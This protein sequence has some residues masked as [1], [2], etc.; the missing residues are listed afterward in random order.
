MLVLIAQA[1]VAGIAIGIT[2]L[3]ASFLIWLYGWWR[4]RKMRRES[5]DRVKRAIVT[6]D[7]RWP[8]YS[9]YRYPSTLAHPLGHQTAPV[10]GTDAEVI[11]QLTGENHDRI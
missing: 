6:G 2:L 3:A 8:T 9:Y 7:I 4:E 5:I 1:F 11:E 10:N